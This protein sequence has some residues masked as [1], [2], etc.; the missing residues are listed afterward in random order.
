MQHLSNWIEI[1]AA[2]IA[3]ATAFYQRVLETELM[4]MEMAGHRYALF[5]AQNHYNTGAL[6]QGEGYTPSAEGPLVYLDGRGELDAMLERVQQAGGRV[7]LPR[8]YVSPEAGEIALFLDS[9]G[10]RVG[11]QSSVKP[12]RVQ[13]VSDDEMRQLLASNVPSHAFLVRRGPRFDDPATEPL[14]WEHARNMLTLMRGGEL[15]YVCAL[16]DGTDVLGFGVLEAT[17]RDAALARLQEDPGVRAGRLT[18]QVLHGVAFR[19]DETR[20]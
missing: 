13:P 6:V 15:R 20:V 19:A 4:P 5:P 11:L 14:H 3:R 8:T 7:L 2:D 1:P 12:A 18:V 16:M 9:E 10:N 17:T